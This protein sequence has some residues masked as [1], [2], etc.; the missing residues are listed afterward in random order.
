MPRG[1]GKHSRK[2]I[3][4]A[5]VN[6]YELLNEMIDMR[7]FSNLWFW[8]ALAVMWSATSHRVLGVPF[9]MVIRAARHKDDAEN[10]PQ[11]DLEDMVR[12]NVNRLLYISG[13]SG[14]WMLGLGSF[15]FT[16]MILLGFIYDV[17]LAQAVF[18]LLFPLSIVGLLSLNTARRIREEH[19]QGAVLR[20]QLTRHR[21]WVQVIGMLSIFATTIWGIYQNLTVNLPNN[22]RHLG[23]ISHVEQPIDHDR[24]RTRGL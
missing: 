14:L 4:G 1:A 5:K 24:G 20:K 13:V 15:L 2:R 22:F 7:S 21:V 6:W 18:C 11:Q 19:I 3:W 23:Q 16:I 8:I 10:Q 12:I 17:Q 9:D